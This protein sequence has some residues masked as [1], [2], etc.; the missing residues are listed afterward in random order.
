MVRVQGGR[1]GGCASVLAGGADPALAAVVC[2]TRD[3]CRVGR[4]GM[5]E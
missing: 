3:K 5:G 4:R 2:V 1:S